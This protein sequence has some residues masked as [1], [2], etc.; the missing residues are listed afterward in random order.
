M[1]DKTITNAHYDYLNDIVKILGFKNLADFDT[2]ITYTK[3]KSDQKQICVELTKSIDSFK[4]L[5]SQEGFDLR[6]INYSFENIEQVIGFVKKLFGYLFINWNYSRIKGISTLRLIPPNNL[7]NKYIM[8]LREIPQKENLILLKDNIDTK[9]IVNQTQSEQNNSTNEYENISPIKPH[10]PSQI[11][12][13]NISDLIQ[14]FEKKNI[15]KKII[16]KNNLNLSHIDIDWI[17]RIKINFEDDTLLPPNTIISLIINQEELLLYQIEQKQNIELEYIPINFPNNFLYSSTLVNL[18][19]T[20]PIKNKELKETEFMGNLT[21]DLTENLTEDLTDEIKFIVEFDGYNVLN[22][23]FL[24]QNDILSSKKKLIRFDHEE[25]YSKDRLDIGIYENILNIGI[26]N[27][28][29]KKNNYNKQYDFSN[30]TISMKYILSYVKKP[31]E[32]IYKIKNKLDTTILP[33]DYFNWIKIRKETGS[34]IS[35]GTNIEFFIGGIKVLDYIINPNTKFDKENYYKFD[36]DFPNIILYKYHIAEIFIKEPEQKEKNEFNNIIVKGSQFK[37][38]LPKKFLNSNIL[39]DHDSKWFVENE[40]KYV[41]VNGMVFNQISKENRISSLV[42]EKKH[43]VMFK[44]YEEENK[45]INKLIQ[46]KSGIQD[47]LI[48]MDNDPTELDIDYNALIY[49]VDNSVREYFKIKNY[50]KT[51]ISTYSF[52]LNQLV[53]KDKYPFVC[54]YVSDSKYQLFYVISRTSDLI[55]HFDIILND[56]IKSK[57][58]FNSWI[59]YQN[60]IIYDFGINKI[61]KKIRLNINNHVFNILSKQLFTLNLVIEI[62]EKHFSDWKNIDISMGHIYSDS[63]LRRKLV[64]ENVFDEPEYI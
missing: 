18:K 59:E 44:K 13:I 23:N 36:I 12:Q 40:K 60:K 31:Y 64:Y 28:Y 39:F 6:K 20:L 61:N 16:T 52:G 11:P 55:K 17:N 48:F 53:K 34:K 57:Y 43:I 8:N 10:E 38:T 14:Q 26:E 19:I 4:K 27:I 51:D 3:L 58:T 7:Y 2:T 25:L 41:S 24:I 9:Q 56:S 50:L 63:S 15:T 46:L 32:K 33:F 37:S 35:I 30:G 62:P 5:F 29:L 49:I 22:K 54:E 1:K 47:N 21:E 45:I 42:D